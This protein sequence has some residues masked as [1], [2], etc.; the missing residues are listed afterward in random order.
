[1]D[2]NSCY[3]CYAEVANVV[4][5]L[6]SLYYHQTKGKGG[7]D[8]L[9]RIWRAMGELLEE[10]LISKRS[11]I[12]TDFFH[13]SVKLQKVEYYDGM[14]SF[15]KPQFVLLPDFTSK[16]HLQNVLTTADAHYHA[17][18]PQFISYSAIADV[19]GTDRFV[20][21]AAIQ[22]ST[23]EIGKY[24][25]RNPR[26]VLRIDIGIAFLEFRGREY[27]IKWT[28][29]FLQR[30]TEAVGPRSYVSPYDPPPMLPAATQCRFRTDCLSKDT[31]QTSLLETVEREKR[32][33]V[34]EMNDSKGGSGFRKSFW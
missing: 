1:M 4:A 13:A 24:L 20:V 11:C 10:Q 33:A 28:K 12:V 7:T 32:L 31:L 23:R 25:V 30:F 14:C 8:L 34:V 21:E 3:A 18:V 17:T 5:N 6:K 15:Y 9:H 16:F 27:R 22:D 2:S 26:T 29:E 19:A